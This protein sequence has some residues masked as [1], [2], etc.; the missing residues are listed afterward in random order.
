VLDAHRGRGLGEWL[1]G[2]ALADPALQ[3][4]RRLILATRDAHGLYERFG[5]AA[6]KWPNAYMDIVRPDI[7]LGGSGAGGAEAPPPVV[8]LD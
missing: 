7:Y 4:L 6:P 8:R 1:V 3:G 2:F 5:F